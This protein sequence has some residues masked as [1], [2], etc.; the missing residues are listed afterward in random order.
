MAAL[1]HASAA[2]RLQGPLVSRT[3]SPPQHLRLHTVARFDS[4]KISELD[5]TAQYGELLGRHIKVFFL[6][7]SRTLWHATA[8][9]ERDLLEACTKLG[10]SLGVRVAEMS[11][12]CRAA[13]GRLPGSSVLPS[14]EKPKKH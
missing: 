5:F 11:A 2:D 6:L 7:S 12:P 8:E 1:D 10:K 13:I 14:T 4:G 9:L 3:P